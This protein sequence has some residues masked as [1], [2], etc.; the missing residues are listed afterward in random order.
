MHSLLFACEDILLHS[1]L[2]SV[3]S[4]RQSTRSKP[5]IDYFLVVDSLKLEG[6]L[7]I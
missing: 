4:Y 2:H 6:R 7:Q 1:K 3:H 5:I